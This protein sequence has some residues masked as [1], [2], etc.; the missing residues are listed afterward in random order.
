MT[1]KRFENLA[2]ALRRNRLAAVP[3]LEHQV[4]LIGSR[5]D[6]DRAMRLPVGQGIPQEIRGHLLESSQ[7][8]AHRTSDM[9]V[10]NDFAIRLAILKFLDYRRQSLTDV[11]DVGQ[12][13]AYSSSQSGTREVKHVIDQRRHAIRICFD[14]R[15]H[16]RECRLLESARQEIGARKNRLQGIAQ[17]MAENRYELLAK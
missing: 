15:R 10:R 7:I 2:Q 17:I 8:A 14:S 3:Y 16:V 1:P 13:N 11:L 4:V 12:F 9:K 5:L 6:L